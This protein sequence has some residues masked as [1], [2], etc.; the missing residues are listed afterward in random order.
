MTPGILH[1]EEKTLFRCHS[2]NAQWFRG[3]GAGSH[4]RDIAIASKKVLWADP[5]RANPRTIVTAPAISAISISMS[6]TIITPCNVSASEITAPIGGVTA[7]APSRMTVFVAAFT[8]NLDNAGG[9]R[10]LQTACGLKHS[11]ICCRAQY[12]RQDRRTRY[13]LNHKWSL[14]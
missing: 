6:M 9:R 7:S 14:I 10:E 3:I 8:F 13:Y 1:G 2:S 11:R 12:E 5:D 4:G